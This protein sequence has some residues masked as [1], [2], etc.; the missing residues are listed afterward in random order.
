MTSLKL[1]LLLTYIIICTSF[2]SNVPLLRTTNKK[3]ITSLKMKNVN[4]FA[5][6]LRRNSTNI[7]ML[8][9]TSE[10]YILPLNLDVPMLIMSNNLTN[11]K[12][13]NIIENTMY[14]NTNNENEYKPKLSKG[15]IKIIDF[16]TL[17]LNIFNI[18][19]VYF[20]SINDRIIVVY[21]NDYKNVYYI[22]TEYDLKKIKHLIS[23]ISKNIKCIII[24][25]FENVMNS[26]FGYLYCEEKEV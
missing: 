19:K 6:K 17:F 13:K 5:N 3:Y 9:D 18:K 2:I 21:K 23:L 14:N 24:S 25:D 10:K 20:S 11:V 15:C 4:S 7:T 1:L 26:R 16:D 8:E 12:S 22:D